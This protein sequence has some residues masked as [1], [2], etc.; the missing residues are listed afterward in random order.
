MKNVI[1]AAVVASSFLAGCKKDAPAAVEVPKPAAPAAVVEAPKPPP[2]AAASWVVLEKLGAKIEMPAGAKAED[3]SADAANYSVAPEDYSF[4]VMVSTVT[5]A[6][7]STYEA[8]VD[9]VKKMT[10]GFKAFTK[11]EKTADGWVL[12]FEGESMMDKSPLYG[13]VVRKKLGEKSIEC[14]RNESSKAARD[15]VE[16]ACLS[17]A[18]K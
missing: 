5:E 13:V 12:E 2:P 3:T 15:S 17:L 7:P 4:T 10:N 16:K 9:E 1:I 6:Y 8:A 11:N 14:S 18:A